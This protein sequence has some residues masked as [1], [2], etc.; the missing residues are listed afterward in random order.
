M[1]VSSE[2]IAVI[3]LVLTE[4]EALIDGD[5]ELKGLEWQVAQLEEMAEDA[6]FRAII[7]ASI[8][9]EVFVE[10]S[11]AAEG[12]FAAEDVEGFG[13]AGAE[14]RLGGGDADQAE[15]YTGFLAGGFE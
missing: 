14:G 8:S 4:V 15:Q 7:A 10:L 11:D 13:E 5:D 12:G 1:K 6:V 9:D 2:K 3:D